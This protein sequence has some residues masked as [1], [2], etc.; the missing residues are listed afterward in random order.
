MGQFLFR[1]A[2]FFD[3]TFSVC[4]F[5]FHKRHPLFSA[6]L[7]P[8]MLSGSA[9]KMEIAGVLPACIFDPFSDLIP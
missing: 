7:G 1:G 5:S 3:I 4:R 6:G 9:V 8:G 2:L